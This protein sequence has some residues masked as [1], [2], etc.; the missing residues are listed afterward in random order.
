MRK[1]FRLVNYCSVM[2]ASRGEDTT[3]NFLREKNVRTP[4]FF[5]IIF[6]R[7]LILFAFLGVYH[8]FFLWL[9]SLDLLHGLSKAGIS[10]GG[11]A[12]S[13]S[14]SRCF[15]W[16]GWLLGMGLLSGMMDSVINM[17]GPASGTSSSP[18][19]SASTSVGTSLEGHCSG[20]SQT[21]TEPEEFYTPKSEK[22]DQARGVSPPSTSTPLSDSHSENEKKESFTF[23]SE[24][25]RR[26][27]A[28]SLFRVFNERLEEEDKKGLIAPIP[29]SQFISTF[30]LPTNEER[31]GRD[32]EFRGRGQRQKLSLSSNPA[33][34]ERT[35]EKY[36]SR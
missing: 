14:V 24:L 11:R 29:E 35:P 6:F 2:A 20:E 4:N 23:L 31:Y 19:P 21:S 32:H 15:G 28:K 7:L 10:L 33:T 8:C 26:E 36:R 12:L 30:D 25:G 17:M 16:E 1:C 9:G 5:C 18:S 13:F 27:W 3:T 22:E 34:S